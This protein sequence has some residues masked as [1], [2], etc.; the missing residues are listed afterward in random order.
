MAEYR[1]TQRYRSSYGE[2]A[3]GDV[4]ELTEAEAEAINRDAPGTLEPVKSGARAVEKAPSNRQVTAAK[5][6]ADRGV[7]EPMD[8]STFKA[9]RGK[10]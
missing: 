6:R 4:V 3:K 1:F 9:V 7:Q 5:N 10:R 2:G 8:T